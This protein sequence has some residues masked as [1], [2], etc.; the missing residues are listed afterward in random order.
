MVPID[1]WTRAF[2]LFT[3]V[4]LLL[5]LGFLFSSFSQLDDQMVEQRRQRPDTAAA[6][7]PPKTAPAMNIKYYYVTLDGVPGADAMNSGRREMFLEAWKDECG[8]GIVFEEC[9]GVLDPLKGGGLTMTFIKCLEAAYGG[10]GEGGGGKEP[11]V[12]AVFFFEDDARPFDGMICDPAHRERI[13]REAPSDAMVLLTGGHGFVLR[14]RQE[15]GGGRGR[16]EGGADG[17]LL[18][19]YVRL[20]QS[21]GTYGFAVVGEARMRQVRDMLEQE[22]EE[23]F[24]KKRKCSPDL[25]IYQGGEGDGIYAVNPLQVDHMQGAF[26][27]TWSELRGKAK[28]GEGWMGKRDVRDML[29]KLVRGGPTGWKNTD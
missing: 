25:C 12:D 23:C 1:F 2:F 18:V 15:G 29:G 16:E 4:Y 3:S 14:E 9:T 17:E 13:L 26:S 20:K 19:E 21:F 22:R 8:D 6:A 28:D 24:W 5:S 7:R 11:A 10:G 27:N